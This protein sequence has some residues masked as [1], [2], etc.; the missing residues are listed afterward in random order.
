M[1]RLSDVQ[2]QVL[3]TWW[4]LALDAAN[5]G[6]TSTDLT[7]AAADISR[8]AGLSLAFGESQALAVLYGYANRIAHARD[9][10]GRA[11][12]ESVITPDMIGVP[13]WAR[14]EQVMLTTPIWH[15]TFTFTY[16]D[17]AGNIQTDYR[18]SIF[19]MTMPETAGE[20]QDAITADA[21]AL[22][23]KYNVT[24][25]DASVHEILAV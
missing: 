18:T 10:L 1:A 6:L 4:T 13:P 16:L 24:F 15:V 7:A 21:Q 22:A 19:E 25:Q 20:L 11:A 2:R 14:D 8:Q 17:Q 9:E 5:R 23:D 12:P 3:G